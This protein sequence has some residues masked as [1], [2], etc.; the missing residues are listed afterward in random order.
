MFDLTI[1]TDFIY[2]ADLVYDYIFD[3]SIEYTNE[4]ELYDIE[5]SI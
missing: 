4:F 1:E 5:I 2:Q 3:I